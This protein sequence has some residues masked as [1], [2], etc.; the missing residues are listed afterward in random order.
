MYKSSNIFSEDN[1]HQPLKCSRGITVSLLHSMAHECAINGGKSRLPHVRQ[2]NVYL[3]IR[4]GHI[5]LRLIFTLSNII[6]DLLL[7]R[8]GGHVLFRIL[9]SFSAIYESMKFGS[10]FL[11]DAEHWGGLR[12]IGL[13]PP[14]NTFIVLDFVN[15]L[16]LE[17]IKTPR[18]VVAILLFLIDDRNLMIHFSKRWKVVWGTRQDV[19]SRFHPILSKVGELLLV[20]S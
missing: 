19:L 18:Q 7:V 11:K 12:H 16:C 6:S 3:F 1:G 4:V 10:A 20:L 2:F 17:G 8:K 9:I 5:D 14:S 13:L 15:Q